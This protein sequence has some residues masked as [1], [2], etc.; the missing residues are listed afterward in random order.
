MFL[1]GRANWWTPRWLS[2]MPELL[3]PAD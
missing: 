3:E 1:M 2:R